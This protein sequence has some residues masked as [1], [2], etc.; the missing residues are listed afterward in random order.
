VLRVLKQYV[1]WVQKSVQRTWVFGVSVGGLCAIVFELRH[2][3]PDHLFGTIT[4]P[5]TI[6]FVAGCVGDSG[7]EWLISCH[8]Q[9]WVNRCVS[10]A[11]C[12]AIEVQSHGVEV[13]RNLYWEGEIIRAAHED[14]RREGRGLAIKRKGDR[15]CSSS[16][17]TGEQLVVR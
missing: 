16:I 2:H 1:R 10:G 14:A 6:V 9:Q 4:K 3:R 8:K 17:R 5:V 11:G 13:L 12:R 15:Q 7:R